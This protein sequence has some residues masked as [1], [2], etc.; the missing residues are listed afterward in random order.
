MAGEGFVPLIS[1][2]KLLFHVLDFT[3]LSLINLF[4]SCSHWFDTLMNLCKH[5]RIAL[6]HLVHWIFYLRCRGWKIFRRNRVL[7]VLSKLTS[8]AT[9][10][11]LEYLTFQFTVLSS[12]LFKFK[13]LLYKW[14]LLDIP[15]LWVYGLPVL[16]YVFSDSLYRLNCTSLPGLCLAVGLLCIGCLRHYVI[17]ER[18]QLH[19]EHVFKCIAFLDMM[20]TGLIKE[21]GSL[22]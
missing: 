17:S 1:L 10:M 12:Q 5:L 20:V 3:S 6:Q 16:P 15:H 22:L 2:F 14:C 9:R 4:K 19:H 11:I 7:R 13:L 18:Y 8:K 21:D